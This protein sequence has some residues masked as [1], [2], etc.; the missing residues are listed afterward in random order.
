MDLNPSQC[1]NLYFKMSEL[2][3]DACGNRP[4]PTHPAIPSLLMQPEKQ[5][6]KKKQKEKEK[7]QEKE[8]EKEK[9][10]EAEGAGEGEG[11]GG[12]GEFLKSNRS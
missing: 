2:I 5:K 7:E 8:K 3:E 6:E 12:E 10:G 11:D 4:H 9:E 1:L